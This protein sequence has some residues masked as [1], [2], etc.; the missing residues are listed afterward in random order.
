M[1]VY[2]YLQVSKIKW[3]STNYLTD[4]TLEMN[5]FKFALTSV[6]LILAL[7]ASLSVKVTMNCEK[8]SDQL[9]VNFLFIRAL[10]ILLPK[11]R[12]IIFCIVATVNIV[13]Y[14]TQSRLLA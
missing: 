5:F 6:S 1:Y 12:L 11:S 2:E 7:L 3:W 10:A 14:H 13:R 8:I 4:L 9:E